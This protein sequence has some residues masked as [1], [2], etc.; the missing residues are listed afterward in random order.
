MGQWPH[1]SFRWDVIRVVLYVGALVFPIGKKVCCI[2][3]TFHVYNYM[4]VNMQVHFGM[5]GKYYSYI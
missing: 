1:Q 4:I 2:Y 3:M 5:I